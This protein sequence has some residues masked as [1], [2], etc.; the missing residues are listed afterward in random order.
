MSISERTFLKNFQKERI[1]DM[2]IL[3]AEEKIFSAPGK[4]LMKNEKLFMRQKV[5]SI[6]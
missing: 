1:I 6:N 3:R 5:A 2:N 4:S